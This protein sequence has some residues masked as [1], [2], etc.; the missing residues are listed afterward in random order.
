M[1]FLEGS[2]LVITAVSTIIPPIRADMLGVSPVI[3]IT[4]TG[5]SK[6]SKTG[7]N[8]ASTAD[9]CFMALVNKM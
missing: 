8:T 7:I 1:E 2:E 9:T 5:L 6:G 3:K 4:H